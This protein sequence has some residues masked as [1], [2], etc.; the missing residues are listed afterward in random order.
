MQFVIPQMLAVQSSPYWIL[1]ELFSNEES[2]KQNVTFMV[3]MSD[4]IVI[5]GDGEYPAVY[6]KYNTLE[7][8][9]MDLRWRIL[10][11][12]YGALQRSFLLELTLINL[13][14]VFMIIGM[15]DVKV[16]IKLEKVDVDMVKIIIE[17][18]VFRI[19]T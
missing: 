4:E 11:E 3:D 6:L 8:S 18:F 15:K 17:N 10:G 2:S 12:E 14:M 13:K 7:Q 9:H 1:N 5:S 16:G 19:K